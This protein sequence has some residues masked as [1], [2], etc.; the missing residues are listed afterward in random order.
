M[1]RPVEWS[2]EQVELLRQLW[3]KLPVKE[4]AGQ[5]G[6]NKGAVTGKAFRLKLTRLD[7]NRWNCKTRCV[8]KAV[9]KTITMP[10]VRVDGLPTLTELKAG[11]CH[12]P[13]NEGAPYRFCGCAASRVYCDGHLAMAYEGRGNGRAQV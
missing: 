2:D 7:R 11:E 13:V 1:A 5:L 12:W 4:I 3:G 9:P 10:T 8:P 6:M